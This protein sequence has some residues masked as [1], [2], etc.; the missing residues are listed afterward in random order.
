MSVTA[1]DR[2]VSALH[3]AGCTVVDKGDHGSAST[4]GHSGSDRGTTFRRYGDGV[5][6]YCHNGDRDQVLGELGLTQA[7]L[8]DSPRTVYAYDDGRTVTRLYRNGERQFT[9]GGKKAGTALFGAA[10]LPADTAAPVYVVEGEKDVRAANSVGAAAVSQAQGASMSPGKA[11]WSPLAG[12]PVIVVADADDPGR[13]RAE[14]VVQHLRRIAASVTLAE[15]KDGKDLADHIA[16]G[17]GLGD[18]VVI[19]QAAP[20]CVLRLVSFDDIQDDVPTWAWHYGGGGRIAVGTLGLFAG[21]PGAGKSTAGRWIAAQASNGTLEGCWFGRP[22]NVAYIAAEESLKYVVK[23]SLRAAGAN[24]RR[25]FLPRVEMDG[26]EVRLSAAHAEILAGQLVAHDVRVVIVDPLM[27]TLGGKV[28]I[29]RNNE[30]RDLLEPWAKLAEDIDGVVIGIAHL[31]K[32][33]NGDVVAGINGSSAFGE[34]ARA[35]FGFAK[36]PESPDGDRIM[37]QEKNSMGQEDLAL[38]Y[39][40]ESQ[41][42]TTDSGDSA[43]VARF[44]IIGASDRTVG[45]VLRTPDSDTETTGA[46]TEAEA[47]LRLYLAGGREVDAAEVKKAA[48]DAGI[49]ERTLQRARG[50]LKIAPELRGSPPRSFWAL[51]ATVP[52]PAPTV[53]RSNIGTVGTDGKNA[54]QAAMP[55]LPESICANPA[56]LPARGTADLFDPPGKVSED[57]CP[58][59]GYPLGP[60]AAAD[61]VH[62][63]CAARR[64]AG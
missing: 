43:E 39:R 55:T 61:G 28:D 15:P 41:K 54:G 1:Y 36:D 49:S 64:A 59:C 35:V 56:T 3:A 30:V 12:R 16:A 26:K 31:R 57:P 50:K 2:L 24:M 27:S 44:A 48:K 46:R 19:G 8:F 14:K 20:S 38:T 4:P 13:A 18:L 22:V 5:L 10:A 6:L 17:H 37:S 58:E 47:W 11:D 51:P 7:D 25:V 52:T 40:I 42:V 23:P 33:G 32:S 34:V 9:Q 62:A 21:R 53:A 60:L 63:D 45:D 29:N